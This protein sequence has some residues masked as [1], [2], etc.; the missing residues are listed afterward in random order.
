MTLAWNPANARSPYRMQSARSTDEAD[1]A[2]LG[3]AELLTPDGRSLPLVAA[4][5]RVDAGGGL[6]RVVLEQT[7]ENP[8][9]DTLRV[10]YKM[11]LPVD[12]PSEQKSS[13]CRPSLR[14][15]PVARSQSSTCGPQWPLYGPERNATLKPLRA[16]ARTRP[17]LLTTRS[18]LAAEATLAVAA[19]A[20]NASRERTA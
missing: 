8:Y 4:K 18:A 16:S 14:T 10:T 12:G 17:G 5:L 3:G 7:F 13:V 9:E 11:P 6:A 1:G 20:A 15:P 2:P 19:T